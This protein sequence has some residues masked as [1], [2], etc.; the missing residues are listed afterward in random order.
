MDDF[1][2]QKRLPAETA[3]SRSKRSCERSRTYAPKRPERYSPSSEGSPPA[4]EIKR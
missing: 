1:L 3:G 4:R 2:D